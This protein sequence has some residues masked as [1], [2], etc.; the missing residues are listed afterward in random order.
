V[1]IFTREYLPFGWRKVVVE[2]LGIVG[3]I[4]EMILRRLAGTALIFNLAVDT[5]SKAEEGLSDGISWEISEI[6]E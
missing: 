5:K 3:L 4:S 6:E 1:E 2:V